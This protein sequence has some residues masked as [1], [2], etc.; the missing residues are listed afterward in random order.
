MPS[1]EE[2]GRMV[3]FERR[4][5]SNGCTVAVAVYAR[6]KYEKMKTIK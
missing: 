3:L 5:P 4:A 6:A 1:P 2:A